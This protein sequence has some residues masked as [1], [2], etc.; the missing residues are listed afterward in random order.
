MIAVV[1]TGGWVGSAIP[2][3][4]AFQRALRRPGAAQATV[5][6]RIVAAGA[7]SAFGQAHGLGRV[8]G[9]AAFA[10][11][12]PVHGWDGL[13]PWITRAAGGEPDVL[14]VGAIDRFEP[15]SGTTSGAK[16]IPS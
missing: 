1:A 2:A 13:A 6:R 5:L 11:A 12:V 10:R 15:T 4:T 9:P 14:T 16:W 7:R 8:D 3:W